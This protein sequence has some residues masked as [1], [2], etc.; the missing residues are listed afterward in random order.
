MAL[1]YVNRPF[2]DFGGGIDQRSAPNAI[3]ET[4]SEDLQNAYHH[5]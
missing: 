5:D 3:P 1:N 4:F 2:K